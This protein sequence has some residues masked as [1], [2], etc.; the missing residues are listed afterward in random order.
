VSSEIL[1]NFVFQFTVVLNDAQIVLFLACGNSSYWLLSS[2][3]KTPVVEN[4]RQL[5]VLGK[6]DSQM[7]KNETMPLSYTIHKNQHQMD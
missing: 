1:T 4:S 5:M 2:F 3:D 7:Q 6:L